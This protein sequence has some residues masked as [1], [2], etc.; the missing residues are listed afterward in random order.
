MQF[1]RAYAL[2]CIP[3]S[4]ALILVLYLSGLWNPPGGVFHY[5][6]HRLLEGLRPLVACNNLMTS[7]EVV[8]S[9]SKVRDPSIALHPLQAIARIAVSGNVQ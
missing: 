9:V 6:P 5:T 7:Y 3:L 4:T 8:V 2:P 1:S